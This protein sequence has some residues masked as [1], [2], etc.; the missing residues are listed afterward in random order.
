[1]HSTWNSCFG[2]PSRSTTYSDFILAWRFVLQQF[3]SLFDCQEN[4]STLQQTILQLAVTGQLVQHPSSEEN[5]KT[6]PKRDMKNERDLTKEN[7]RRLSALENFRL[8]ELPKGWKWAT[9]G[10]IGDVITGGTPTK[11][12][13]EYYGSDFA[14]FKPSDLNSGYY[15]D[16]STDGLSKLGITQAKLL[17]R[18]SVLVTCIGASIGK[19]GLTRI[20]GASNQQI[21]S[22]FRI[23]LCFQNLCILFVYLHNFSYILENLHQRLLFLFSTKPNSKACHFQCPQ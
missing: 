14:F 8:T 20:E 9:V 18:K 3:E 21:N 6:P 7:T 23:N 22:L 13:Q 10:Q 19:T 12:K 1:M 15:V 2:R 5:E 17:P 16:K 4:V 11:S